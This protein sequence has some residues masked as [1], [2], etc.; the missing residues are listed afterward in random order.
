MNELFYPIKLAVIL[1]Q[2]T[3]FEY[4]YPLLIVDNLLG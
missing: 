1:F 4:N 3:E 2:S